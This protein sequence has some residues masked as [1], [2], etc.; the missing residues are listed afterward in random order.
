MNVLLPVNKFNILSINRAS[1]LVLYFFLLVSCSKNYVQLGFNLK[2]NFKGKI[3]Q[4]SLAIEQGLQTEINCLEKGTYY[5]S[6]TLVVDIKSEYI[7]YFFCPK[8]LVFKKNMLLNSDFNW[9]L[10]GI[11]DSVEVFVFENLNRNIILF[12]EP[13]FQHA[14]ALNTPLLD[15]STAEEFLNSN[16]SPLFKLNNE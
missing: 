12:R 16:I 4:N 15:S 11:E 10:K 8:G 6:K 2:Y 5:L 7:S 9:T 3:E 1:F 13:G 14:I